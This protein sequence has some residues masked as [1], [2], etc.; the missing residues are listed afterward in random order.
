MARTAI[1]IPVHNRRAVTLRCLAGL[2]GAGVLAWA[3]VFVVDDGSTDGT[4]E[5][6]SRAFPSVR[7]L[8]G[9]GNLWWGGAIRLGMAAAMQEG[10]DFL[11]WLNDDCSPDP[12]TIRL[13]VDHAART[14]GIAAGWAMTPSGGRYGAYRKT[15]RGFRPVPIP[16][17][18]G[19]AACDA[20]AGNCVVFA[21]QVVAAIGLPD[22]AR[23]PHAL[24][25]VDYTLTATRRGF[26]LDLLGSAVCRNDDN[27]Q[28]A[29]VSWLLDEQ[30]PMEQWKLLLRPHSTYNYRASFRLHWRHWGVWGLWLYA[31]SYLKLALVCGLRAVV[32]LRW[33]RAL[34][35]ARSSAWR[36]RRFYQRGEVVPAPASPPGK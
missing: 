29:A 25:D 15:W 18:G 7:M 22:A 31:R 23:L 12:G 26:G 34:Y 17:P 21:R 14:S 9:D 11:A 1:I 28:P 13:L 3:Q 27:L 19:V 6:V 33:L 30:S 4:G 35:A 32:P 8:P 5:A 24:L 16:E 36:R 2:E 10:A 20:A